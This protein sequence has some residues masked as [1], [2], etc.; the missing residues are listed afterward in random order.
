MIHICVPS[1]PPTTNNAYTRLRNGITVPTAAC[2][3]YKAETKTYIAQHYPQELKFF[4]ANR[5]YTVL[6][7]ITFP[8]RD[9]LFCSTWPDKAKN[10]FQKLDASNRIKIFEDAF[11]EAAGIDDSHTFFFGI[12]KHW[13]TGKEE[14]N[15]WAWCPEVEADPIHELLRNLRTART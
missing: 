1:I 7:Q 2:K 9:D 5:M 4:E 11:A 12:N 3:K 14:M 15:L 8:E 10:R 13:H 6:A